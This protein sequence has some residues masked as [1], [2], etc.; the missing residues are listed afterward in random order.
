MSVKTKTT[1]RTVEVLKSRTSRAVDMAGSAIPFDRNDQIAVSAV[2]HKSFIGNV[3]VAL[4][5]ANRPVAA[6]RDIDGI[7]PIKSKLVKSV[8]FE[9]IVRRLKPKT[10]YVNDGELLRNILNE[11][12]LHV[13]NNQT[14]V[15]I[16]DEI[17]AKYTMSKATVFSGA[18]SWQ[19]NQQ[20]PNNQKTN[21]SITTKDLSYSEMKMLDPTLTRRE[22]NK[23]ACNI[24]R[25]KGSNKK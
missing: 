3:L 15:Q 20:Q 19:P 24:N 18:A 21:N 10:L 7:V 22:Y 2:F 12:D 4:N 17:H 9:N 8:N 11:Q 23:I 6:W 16:L 13:Y 1:I 5:A 25:T 14:L